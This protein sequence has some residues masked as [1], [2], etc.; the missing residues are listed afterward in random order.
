MAR[1]SMR[2]GRPVV[3]SRQLAATRSSI[4]PCF[5]ITLLR[6]RDGGALRCRQR[7]VKLHA[8]QATR[9]ALR[10]MHGGVPSPAELPVGSAP[11]RRYPLSQNELATGSMAS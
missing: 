2:T 4:K 3:G 9:Q 11:I 6:L 8:A 7:R 10:R 5:A 1:V